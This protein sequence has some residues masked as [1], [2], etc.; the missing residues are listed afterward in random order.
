MFFKISK[1][2]LFSLFIFFIISAPARSN[3][4]LSEVLVYASLTPV[5]KQ[6][7]ANSITIVDGDD[8]RNR[9]VLN[10]GQIHSVMCQVW[11]LVKL[12]DTERKCR[13]VPGDLNLIIF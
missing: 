9:G 8:V 5:L 1:K 11:R 2:V 3:D 10:I 7:S 12:E 13:F 6:N 4:E